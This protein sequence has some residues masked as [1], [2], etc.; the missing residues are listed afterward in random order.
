MP[1]FFIK[2]IAEIM[3]GD[4]DAEYR[5]LWYMIFRGTYSHFFYIYR[6]VFYF[7]ANP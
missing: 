3:I 6:L 5:L 1:K 7:G 4:M 2:Y